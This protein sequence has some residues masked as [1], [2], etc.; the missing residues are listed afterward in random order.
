MHVPFLLIIEITHFEVSTT[1]TRIYN[2]N[3]YCTN[4]EITLIKAYMNDEEAKTN[5]FN[6]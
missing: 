4:L 5:R 3:D 6:L 1:S 2:I